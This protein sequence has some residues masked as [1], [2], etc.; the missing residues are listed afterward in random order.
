[1][2]VLR[3]WKRLKKWSKLDFERLR[4]VGFET[5]SYA[6]PPEAP[7]IDKAQ[8]PSRSQLGDQRGYALRS[9]CQAGI[10]TCG[11][12]FPGGRST[13]D[14]DCGCEGRAPA[15]GFVSLTEARGRFRPLA[16][17][18]ARPTR[19]ATGSRSNTMCLPTRRTP[20]MR[21]ASS[22]ETISAAVDFSGS[23]FDPNQTD[24]ITSPVTREAS[25]RAI[26]STSGNSGMKN[27]LQS[28]VFS[29]QPS[30]LD[31]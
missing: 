27:S 23:G 15:P 24:S 3:P 7:R 28:S 13:A 21:W 17:E 19:P 1:M 12:S 18:G 25:P 8:F 22:V 20:A 2:G 30:Q 10:P 6:E 9:H 11:P 14:V 4:A 16:G 29:R 5:A 31:C 26:V